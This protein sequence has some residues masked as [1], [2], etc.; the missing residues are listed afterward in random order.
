MGFPG[1]ATRL[2]LG[3]IWVKGLGMQSINMQPSAFAGNTTPTSQV[4][5]GFSIPVKAGSTFSNIAMITGTAASGTTPTTINLGVADPT[6]TVRA[7]SA[8]VAANAGFTAA[9][10]FGI[11]LGTTIQNSADGLWYG[12]ILV[13]GTWS[14]TNWA[15]SRGALVAAVYPP[16]GANYNYFTFGTALTS[17]PAPGSVL[18]PSQLNAPVWFWCGLY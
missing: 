5:F 17:I 13:N 1:G 6:L 9:G 14:V 2:D 15:A 11:P 10:I 16:A 4:G 3:D 7:V 12:L 8:N 18:T